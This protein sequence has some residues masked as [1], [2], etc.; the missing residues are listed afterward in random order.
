MRSVTA[1]CW[2]FS[3]LRYC[4]CMVVSFR[5][6]HLRV[7]IGKRLAVLS[8][9]S[10]PFAAYLGETEE[11]GKDSA[12]GFRR[13]C[14]SL[15]AAAKAKS[16]L[17]ALVLPFKC[18]AGWSFHTRAVCISPRH[19]MGIRCSAASLPGDAPRIA[20]SL[21]CIAHFVAG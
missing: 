20:Q 5:N 8:R 13:R 18:K 6:L 10:P 15:M 21:F 14:I 19:P 12:A 9:L 2:R 17:M 7:R 4:S 11:N 3:S 16:D 1:L